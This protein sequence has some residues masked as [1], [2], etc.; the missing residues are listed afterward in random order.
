MS[1]S[2]E[3]SLAPK[4]LTV[5]SPSWQVQVA[6][7]YPFQTSMESWMCF[8]NCCQPGG[9]FLANPPICVS[10]V[11]ISPYFA[12]HLCFAQDSSIPL[13]AVKLI[14]GSEPKYTKTIF[15]LL[16]VADLQNLLQLCK[17]KCQDL[18]PLL[19]LERYIMEHWHTFTCACFHK[20]SEQ[21]MLAANQKKH[22]VHMNGKPTSPNNGK[23]CT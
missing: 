12:C 18:K 21:V 17:F 5:L 20:C 22:V 4:N 15:V 6:P 13:M 10:C 8:L 14:F 23:N 9:N 19:V 2:C 7:W 11:K 16:K 3:A 1:A